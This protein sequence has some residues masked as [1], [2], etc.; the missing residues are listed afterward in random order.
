MRC[1]D[2]MVWRASS[3]VPGFAKI[4]RPMTMLLKKNSKFAWT[5]AEEQSF[6]EIKAKLVSK[7]VLKLYNPQASRTELH[8][9]ASST[10]LGGMLM[11]SDSEKDPLQLVYVISRST[12]ECEA[13]YHSSRLELMAVAWA[14][15]RLK[16]LLIGLKFVIVTDCQNLVHINAWKTKNAQIARWMSEISDY[17][18]EIKHKSGAQMQHV[19]AL[20]RAPINEILDNSRSNIVMSIDKREDEVLLFQRSDPFITEIM[21]IFQKDESERDNL[22][23]QRVRDF[24]MREGVLFKKVNRDNKERELYVVPNVMRKSLVIRYHNLSSHF[25]VEKTANRIEQYYYFPKLRRYVKTHIKNC[26]ECIL[27]KRKAGPGDG[28][29]HPIPPG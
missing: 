5:A 25:G 27:A 20:S 3:G 18:V 16:P 28:E 21:S 1:G 8:T 9:D 15:A 26:L 13:K 11:Q 2:F 29:L 7:P 19:D 22:E 10:G 14:L 23:K 6:Q 24:V 17:D 4:A 12:T